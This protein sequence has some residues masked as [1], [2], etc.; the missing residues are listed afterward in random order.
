MKFGILLLI[1]V[2]LLPSVSLAAGEQVL[3]LPE[4]SHRWFIS[5]VGQAGE[6]QYDAILAAFDATDS[7]RTLKAQVH[8]I[9]VTADSA[10]YQERYA[11]GDSAINAL[12][13]IRVQTDSGVIV[14]QAAGNVPTDPALL[15][16]AIAGAVERHKLL[17]LFPLRRHHAPPPAP[18]IKPIVVVAPPVPPI[19][20]DGPPDVGDHLWFGLGGVLILALAV[21]IAVGIVEGYK[22]EGN[23]ERT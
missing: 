23:N 1:V 4:D 21:G 5:V 17:P 9:P 20:C 2:S 22:N 10:V 8:F 11:T 6:S 15:Y 3:N 19:N 12:P 14:Y 18:V 16:D 7:M 13:A